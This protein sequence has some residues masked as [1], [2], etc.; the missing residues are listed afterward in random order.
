MPEFDYMK[1]IDIIARLMNASVNPVL[2]APGEKI[3]VIDVATA[4]QNG[5]PLT[6]RLIMDKFILE[7]IIARQHFTGRDPEKWKTSFEYE[8]EQTFFRNIKVEM[9]PENDNFRIK[10]SD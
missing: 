8:L 4:Y 5:S 6:Y 2:T 7:I 1:I 3:T 9:S 10:I